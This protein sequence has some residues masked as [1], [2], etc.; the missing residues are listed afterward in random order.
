MALF[1]RFR[2]PVTGRAHTV[3]RTPSRRTPCHA[4]GH[5]ESGNRPDLPSS[6]PVRARSAQFSPDCAANWADRAD[7]ASRRANWADHAVWRPKTGRRIPDL[8]SLQIEC[9]DLPSLWVDHRRTT[10]AVILCG[11]EGC[12]TSLA[13]AF[14]TALPTRRICQQLSPLSCF[15]VELAPESPQQTAK[16]QDLPANRKDERLA[17]RSG[18]LARYRAPK[19]EVEGGLDPVNRCKDPST[20]LRFAQDDGGGL[21]FAQDDEGTVRLTAQCSG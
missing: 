18:N 3:S 9:P 6:C 21:R 2:H 8:P 20:S 14:L 12:L 13:Q 11:V 4:P 5:V 10:S 17:G 16:L 1:Q 7:R 19:G 15:L